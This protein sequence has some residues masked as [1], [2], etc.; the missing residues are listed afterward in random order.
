MRFALMLAVLAATLPAHAQ[1]QWLLNQSTLTWHITHPM[2]EV[3]GTSHSA[4]GKAPARRPVQ[5]SDRGTG[6]ILFT[7]GTVIATCIRYR[8]CGARNSLW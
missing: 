6:K 2:H 8:W 1:N 5:F 3:E 7:P 4:K